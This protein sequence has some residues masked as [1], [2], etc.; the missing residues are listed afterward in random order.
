MKRSENN[1]SCREI[2]KASESHY[3]GICTVQ[4]SCKYTKMIGLSVIEECEGVSTALNILL[5]RFKKM[6]QVCYCNDDCNILKSVSIRLSWI[7]EECLIVSDRF[8]NRSHKCDIVTDLDSYGCCKPHITSNAEYIS[9]YWMFSKS[10]VRFLS[11]DNLIPYIAI[12]TIFINIGALIREMYQT[13]E[14][15]H[16]QH[17]EFMKQ[18]Y[19]CCC[20]LCESSDLFHNILLH[21]TKIIIMMR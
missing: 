4:C 9:Q 6:P 2:Y 11:S 8:H 17:Y 15:K 12:R 19:N 3:P 7:N 1:R 13:Q 20:I 16:Y 21:G 14:V 10:H 18:F 5:S